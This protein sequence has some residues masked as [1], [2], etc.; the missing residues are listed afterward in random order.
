MAFVNVAFG[1]LKNSS[2]LRVPH[3]KW[4]YCS[5]IFARADSKEM[6]WW[7]LSCSEIRWWLGV[8]NWRG[9]AHICSHPL[10]VSFYRG[11]PKRLSFPSFYVSSS[12]FLFMPVFLSL[13]WKLHWWF[14]IP[15]APIVLCSSVGTTY[16]GHGRGMIPILGS[17]LHIWAQTLWLRG[18]EGMFHNFYISWCHLIHCLLHCLSKWVNTSQEFCFCLP[19]Y[20]ILSYKHT[21]LFKTYFHGNFQ[22]Y[23]VKI[24]SWTAP[25]PLQQLSIFTVLISSF[26][27]P[28]FIFV[29]GACSKIPHML[30]MNTTA[31][32]IFNVSFS[33]SFFK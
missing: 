16:G 4:M 19:V 27:S 11:T 24:T 18:V 21:E 10:F 22:T 23:K 7:F 3:G 26:L 9:H 5:V 33:F 13:F 14:G 29:V 6:T 32:L 1:P 20:W 30:P 12:H 15:S 2:I 31:H 8:E 28:S 17:P 25:P